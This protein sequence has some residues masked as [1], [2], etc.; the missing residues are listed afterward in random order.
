MALLLLPSPGLSY[1]GMG[2][3]GGQTGNCPFIPGHSAALC[4]S[5][6]LEHIQ[7]LQSMFAAL[8]VSDI[9]LLALLLF[10]VAA[11]VAVFV[12][13]TLILPLVLVPTQTFSYPLPSPRSALQAVYARGI[14]NSRA[15]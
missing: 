4:Q 7:E 9:F 8:P 10:L 14:L 13:K 1:L 11:L 3:M 2:S 6:P 12:K 15:F 5:N